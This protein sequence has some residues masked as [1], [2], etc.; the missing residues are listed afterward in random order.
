M[1][2]TLIRTLIVY[3]LLLTSMRITGKRQLGELQLSELITALLLS[4]ISVMPLSDLSIPLL[5]AVLPILLIICLEIAIPCIA[6]SSPFFSK[7]LEGHP[8][9]IIKKG[10]LIQKELEKARIG[11]DEL[12]CELRLKN[13]TDISDVEYALL[14]QNGKLSVIPKESARGITLEDMGIE[15]PSRGFAHPIIL[16]G[17]VSEYNLRLVGKDMDWLVKKLDGKRPED[18][19]L[20]TVDDL[21]D[22]RIIEKEKR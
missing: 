22:V 10:V 6:N 19:L 16:S 5:Y 21:G 18:I 8:N 20:L 11:M 7:L 3:I 14:E 15:R 12:I 13:I 2:A 4:E 1:F 17:A 9:I